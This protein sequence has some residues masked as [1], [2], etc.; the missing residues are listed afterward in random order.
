M[1]YVLA[2]MIKKDMPSLWA[3]G[4]VY[5]TEVIY[6]IC[7]PDSSKPPVHYESHT[8]KPHSICH[9]DAP[10]HIIPGAE[11]IDQ[12]FENHIDYFYGP[13]VV[14]KIKNPNFKK[15][16][17]SNI[18]HWEVGKKEIQASLSGYDLQKI[19][20]IFISFDGAGSD[21]FTDSDRAFTISPEA[22]SWLISLPNFN[23]F[24]TIWKS[25][26]FRPGKRDR[27]VHTE[28][29]KRAGIVECLD[30]EKVPAGQYFLSA[31]PIPTAGATESP[32]C[33]V[34]FSESEIR[35]V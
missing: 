5:A 7:S 33:P 28:L 14:I 20:K 11:T 12:L 13:V 34:L 1:P 32:V 35:W 19:E 2:P 24:G 10:G 30:L 29:F 25:T 23:L 4:D 26:D 18:S 21:F 17:A 22:A 3:E 16:D 27:P 15:S 8:F 9:F 31:F 6:D